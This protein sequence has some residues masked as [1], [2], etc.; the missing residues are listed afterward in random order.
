MPKYVFFDLDN[1]LTRSRSA[2]TPEMS[3]LLK[4]LSEKHEVLVVSGANTKQ[5]GVQLGEDMKGK[6]WVMGQNGNMCVNRKGETLWENTMDWTQ[7]LE[8]LAYSNM[9][10]GKRLFRYKDKLDLVQDRGCQISYSLIGHSEDVSKKEKCDPD[11]KKRLMVLK[12]FPFKSKTVEVKI[13][14]TTC[15]DFFVKGY[16]KGRNVEALYKKMKWKKN[17]CLYVGDALFPNGNDETVIG[18]V[19]T[20]AVANPKETEEVIKMILSDKK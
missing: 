10:I 9:I 15:F 6:Y 8:V 5:I 12:K 1:T 18:V 3:K 19:P 13:G 16:N 17:D 2:I 11:Q 7:K 20:R 14:G 4:K